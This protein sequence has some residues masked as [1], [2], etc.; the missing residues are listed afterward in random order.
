MNGASCCFKSYQIYRDPRFA[1]D[2]I[3][4]LLMKLMMFKL[5]KGIRE[6]IRED[7]F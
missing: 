3:Q 6:F 1:F 5:F 2:I 7:W 4:F